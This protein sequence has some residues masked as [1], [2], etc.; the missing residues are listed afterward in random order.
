M[1]TYTLYPPQMT[2]AQ[3]PYQVVAA[4]VRECRHELKENGWQESI[5]VQDGIVFIHFSCQHCGRKLSQS[6]DE[7]LP[8]KTWKGS[9]MASTLA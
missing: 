9:K 8:P 7:V 4:G 3:V 2:P 1:E 6:F 5:A